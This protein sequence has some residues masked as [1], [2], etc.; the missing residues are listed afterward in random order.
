MQ[1]PTAQ[2]LLPDKKQPRL[3]SGGNGDSFETAIVVNADNS[4]V[5][6]E[7]EYSYIAD[8][9]GE[10]HRDW[11]LESQGLREHGGK[12]YDVL[13]IALSSGETR[14]FYFDIANFFTP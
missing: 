6:I 11:N 2:T 5:G 12:P 13:T 3:F 7:A 10:P 14:T 4:L 8:Q 1:D 9:C